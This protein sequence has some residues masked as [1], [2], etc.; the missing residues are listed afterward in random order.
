MAKRGTDKWRRKRR[1]RRRSSRIST[2][3][4]GPVLALLGTLLGIAGL[5]CLFV[6]VALPRLMEF[7]GVEYSGPGVPSPS[8]AA[9]AQPT[10]SPH[11][12]EVFDPASAANEVVFDGYIDYRWFGDPYFYGGK[13]LLTGGKLIDNQSVMNTL[14]QYDP[15]TRS[16]EVLPI[17]PANTHIMYP[18]RSENWLVYLD[19]HAAGGGALMAVDLQSGRY[20]PVKVKDIYTGQPEPMLD[21]DYLAWIDR[22][23]TRMDKLFVCD[24]RTLESTTLVMFSS[25]VYGESLPCLHDGRLYWAD[26]DSGAGENSLIHS[27]GIDESTSHAYAPETYAHD[28]QGNG[29]Y[30]VWLDAHHSED[31][32]LYYSENEGESRKIDTGVVQA[33]LGGHFVAYSKNEAIY[34]YVFENQKTYRVSA[35]HE[36]AMFLGVSGD[37]VIWMDVT[38]RER[39]I[40]KFAQIPG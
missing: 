32:S 22:T 39:D 3:N 40:V 25:S 1:R 15:E 6:F 34:A 30:M 9:S 27:I 20:S 5:V 17:T 24:L 28:P 10:P 4:W 31:C 29:R 11:P 8:P 19:A 38:S 2:S 36:S 16:A 12:M 23:G 18:K 13:M 37:R 26:T 21:G 7:I 14:L 35:D 33:G